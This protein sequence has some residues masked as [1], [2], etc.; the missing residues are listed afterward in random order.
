MSQASRVALATIWLVLLAAAGA[1]LVWT[2]HPFGLDLSQ[3]SIAAWIRSLGA[4]GCLGVIVLMVIHSFLPFPAEIVVLVAGLLYGTAWG[5]LY[6]WLGA[7]AGAALCFWLARWLGRD[8]VLKML[9]PAQRQRLDGWTAAHSPETLLAARLIPVVSFN[10]V[11]YGAGLTTVSWGTFL[12]TTAIGI[13]PMTVAMAFWGEHM[14]RGS[15]QDWLMIGT[16]AVCL[17][18]MVVLARHLLARFARSR[19]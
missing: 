9:T 18:V 6:S 16:G 10:L 17:W 5:A 15:W 3:A 14:Q 8:L 7:M 1:Y 13:L 2:P 4:A 12:W 19:N 11:N